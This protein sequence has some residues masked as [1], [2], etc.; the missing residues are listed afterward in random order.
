MRGEIVSTA[1]TSYHHARAAKITK[2]LSNISRYKVFV[3][4]CVSLI[5]TFDN[6]FLR[7]QV[8]KPPAH[9]GFCTDCGG[10]GFARLPEHRCA[11]RTCGE[12]RIKGLCGAWC[13]Q[14][15][16]AGTADYVSFVSRGTIR[17]PVYKPGGK[18]LGLSGRG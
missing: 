11:Q 8:F 6:F 18:P 10:N 13:T 17:A 12:F 4:V 1:S 7:R 5:S 15:G 16:E 14:D 9:H 3:C 2:F